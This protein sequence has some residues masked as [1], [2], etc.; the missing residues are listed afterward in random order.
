MVEHR[1][2]DNLGPLCVV[3]CACAACTH[4]VRDELPLLQ[5]HHRKYSKFVT[6]SVLL[7]Q[8]CEERFKKTENVEPSLMLLLFLFTL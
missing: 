6:P 2:V 1:N 7:S 4:N 3:V 5:H 8:F